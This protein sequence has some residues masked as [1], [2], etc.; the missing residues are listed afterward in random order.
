MV[1]EHASRRAY[2]SPRRQQQAAATRRTILE[3]AE[4]LFLQDGYPATTMEAI[5]AEAGVSLK[6]AYLPFSTKSGLLRALWDLRLK[7]DDADAPVV[8]HEW[9]RE[10]LEEPDPVRKLQLNA[11]NSAAAKTRIGGLFRVIRGAAEIDADCGALWR[12]IQSDF[13]ANQQMIVESIHRGGGLRRGL[14]VATGTDIL[15]TLN[16]PDAWMLLAGQRGWSPHAYEAWLA[17]T[18][19]AQ[20]LG[21]P[22][23]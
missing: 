3:A 9:F 5:A 16:H 1:K 20:L 4:R 23:T 17:Q 21:T 15:W 7:S 12:L 19:C 10:V 11:R 8:Q 22:I 6:T 14:S 13:Y 18:S 2:N